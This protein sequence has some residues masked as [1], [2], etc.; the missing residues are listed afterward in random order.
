MRPLLAHCRLGRAH[1]H[2]RRG[3]RERVRAETMAALAEYRAMDMP[4][5]RARAEV[6]LTRLG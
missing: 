2:H 1:V 6:E 5:W 3:E 4:Y